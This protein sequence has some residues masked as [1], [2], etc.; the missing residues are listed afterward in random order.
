MESKLFVVLMFF[1]HLVTWAEESCL[2]CHINNSHVLGKGEILK[3]YSSVRSAVL[4]TGHF[5]IPREE[6]R[7]ARMNFDAWKE[8]GQSSFYES[9]KQTLKQQSAQEFTEAVQVLNARLKREVKGFDRVSKA[10]ESEN[11]VIQ[12]Q[13]LKALLNPFYE[14]IPTESQNYSFATT[15][16]SSVQKVL[17]VF[18]G[19]TETMEGHFE[20]QV[21]SLD[22]N[23]IQGKVGLNRWNPKKLKTSGNFEVNWH[24]EL[25][26]LDRK[27]ELFDP[28]LQNCAWIL[29][30]PSSFSSEPVIMI[31]PIALETGRVIKQ[32]EMLAK[33]IVD[34]EKDLK[35]SVLD[36][37]PYLR[38]G[39][40]VV[41]AEDGGQIQIRGGE[42]NAKINLAGG[43]ERA[44]AVLALGVRAFGMTLRAT[45][46][47]WIQKIDPRTS[48]AFEKQKE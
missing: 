17:L 37:E 1:L 43:L 27:E 45:M 26:K 42:G 44:H 22:Q 33:V 46:E 48:R 2:Q 5:W 40:E 34:P 19:T 12:K 21:Q 30:R 9:A 13:A 14:I 41:R 15:I 29:Q 7:S 4:R 23:K 47:Q 39:F 20:L 18:G 38:V 25:G 28:L 11:A 35:L 24:G 10:L 32:E 3:D 6:F 16:K 31:R 36:G 8:T